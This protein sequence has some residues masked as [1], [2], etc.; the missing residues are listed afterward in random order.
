MK[1]GNRCNRGISTA[2]NVTFILINNYTDIISR[3][4]TN[5]FFTPYTFISSKLPSNRI[6][7]YFYFPS[8]IPTEIALKHHPNIEIS[9]K[10]YNNNK[11]VKPLSRK[12]NMYYI[13][14]IYNL[15]ID[16]IFIVNFSPGVL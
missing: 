2:S 7:Y 9:M 8:I 3:F 5:L 6:I 11:I 4:L 16:S 14:V 1:V 12:R 10:H 13:A 15:K